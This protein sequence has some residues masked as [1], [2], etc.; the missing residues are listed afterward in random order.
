MKEERLSRT[1]RMEG[2]GEGRKEG[3]NVPSSALALP[4]PSAPPAND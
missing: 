4:F 3:R 1:V 2:R